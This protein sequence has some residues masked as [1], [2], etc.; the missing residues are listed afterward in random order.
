M[1]RCRI[2]AFYNHNVETNIVATNQSL[3]CTRS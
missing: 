1:A 3:V 2:K